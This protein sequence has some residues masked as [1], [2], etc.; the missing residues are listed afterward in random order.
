MDL[1]NM[2]PHTDASEKFC[3][4][5]EERVSKLEDLVVAAEKKSELASRAY[6][7]SS[8]R[9]VWEDRYWVVR[10]ILMTGTWPSEARSQRRLCKQFFDNLQ[11][12]CQLNV[13]NTDYDWHPVYMVLC[14]HTVSNRNEATCVVLEGVIMTDVPTVTEYGIGAAFDAAWS[15]RIDKTRRCGDDL[16]NCVQEVRR[17]SGRALY[18]AVR[19]VNGSDRTFSDGDDPEY[20]YGPDHPPDGDLAT[21]IIRLEAEEYGDNNFNLRQLFCH[22]EVQKL[23]S[24]FDA[25][26]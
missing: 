24:S 8:F 19:W 23:P 21:V 20:D 6:A 2:F 18:S 25:A 22:P 11:H 5:L 16:Y 4:M 13:N 15:D 26:T 3:L 14:H 9:I 1:N 10:V 17:E 7:G 12:F